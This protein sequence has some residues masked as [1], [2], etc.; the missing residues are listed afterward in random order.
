MQEATALGEAGAVFFTLDGAEA[1]SYYGA[2]SRP[3]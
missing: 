3:R 1:A 2:A